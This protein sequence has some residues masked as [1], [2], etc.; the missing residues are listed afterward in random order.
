[1]AVSDDGA[2]QFNNRGCGALSRRPADTRSPPTSSGTARDL[3]PTCRRGPCV[4]QRPLFRPLVLRD[5]TPTCR[6]AARS[7]KHVPAGLAGLACVTGKVYFEVTVVEGARPGF[8]SVGW[9]G[10]SFVGTEP[11]RDKEAASWGVIDNGNAIHRH[12][13]PLL[14]SE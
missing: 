3:T 6:R 8:A 7:W 1:M 9:A 14:V 12:A 11:G 13:T 2:V 4:T 10:T 5:L